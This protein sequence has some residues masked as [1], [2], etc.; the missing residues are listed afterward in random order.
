MDNT[1]TNSVWE[2]IKENDQKTEKGPIFWFSKW[3][4]RWTQ[5]FQTFETVPPAGAALAPH[6]SKWTLPGPPKTQARAPVVFLNASSS[7]DL[8]VLLFIL[9]STQLYILSPYAWNTAILLYSQSPSFFI[10]MF[11]HPSDHQHPCFKESPDRKGMG[12]AMEILKEGAMLPSW[13]WGR[14]ISH[15]QFTSPSTLKRGLIERA[16]YRATL[17]V[18]CSAPTRSGKSRVEPTGTERA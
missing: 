5:N 1:Y 3:K 6:F 16:D 7:R 8:P 13:H 2:W 15:V 12:E 14:K 18:S 10:F 4:L 11:P 9:V 17:I